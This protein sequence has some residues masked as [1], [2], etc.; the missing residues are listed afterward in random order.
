VT[1]R[2]VLN[3]VVGL[4]LVALF[5]WVAVNTYWTDEQ[6]QGIPRG[7]A[8]INPYY[9]AEQLLRHLDAAASDGAALDALPPAGSVLLLS[10]WNWDFYRARHQ[11]IRG[12]VEAGGRLVTDRTL[13]DSA[14]F[15]AWSGIHGQEVEVRKPAAAGKPAAPADDDTEADTDDDG[16]SRCQEL[17]LKAGATPSDPTAIIWRLCGAPRNFRWLTGRPAQLGLGS[18]VGLQL[19]RV[20]VG[21]GSVTALNA[22]DPYA[23]G[24][25]LSGDHARLLVIATQLHRGDTIRILRG[26]AR[27]SLP[28][29]LWQIGAPLLV[30]LAAA[31]AL[32]L[33]RTMMRFGPLLPAQPPARRS[34]HAQVAGTA[35]FLARNGGGTTLW[36][37]MRNALAE[38][39][40]RRYG[41][42]RA[43][44]AADLAAQLAQHG[45]AGHERLQGA[46]LRPQLDGAEALA[47]ELTLLERAR[48]R[49]Q[50]QI[51]APSPRRGPP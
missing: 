36:N 50:A 10:R 41:R 11:A 20:A 2:P 4:G 45:E 23:T 12:W 5:V 28:A 14:D 33:W 21:R 13:G 39:A 51:S 37:A 7:E 49:L 42:V 31:I 47:R 25:L 22:Y 18:S 15:A 29:W 17:S 32:S 26:D 43:A 6:V 46:L 9:A 16:S 8:V 24:T 44:D 1:R 40:A 38:A 30:L 3:L 27:R 35:S 48:R 19:V 34:L